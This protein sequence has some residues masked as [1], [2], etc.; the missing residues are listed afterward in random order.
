MALEAGVHV[1]IEKPLATSV[2]EGERIIACA[3][4]AKAIAA[5]GYC[6]RFRDNVLLAAELL[7]DGYFGRLT[8]FAF[9]SGQAGGWPS[10]SAYTLSSEATGGGVMMV[11]GTH[12]I[13][14]MLH[15]FGSSDR[16]AYEDDAMGGPEA[17]ATA[18]FF[19]DRG[20]RSFAGIGRLSKL[21]R[22]P[23]GMVLAF[24]EGHLVVPEDERASL[25]WRP[26]S[27]PSLE[28]LIQ[29]RGARRYP[30][31]MNVFQRQL[32]DFIDACRQGGAPMV[33]AEEGLESLRVIEAMYRNR[34]TSVVDWYG[35]GLGVRSVA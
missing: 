35:K 7:R 2:E 33:S 11:N 4:R 6:T 10:V 19:Y 34:S 22:L 12:Y 1:L 30:A 8:S 13:D 27:R 17:H 24:D 15:F 14:R 28:I 21:V 9:Q 32:K 3:R 20:D 16:V 23:S 29:E 18:R 26:R 25:K 31:R 5:V